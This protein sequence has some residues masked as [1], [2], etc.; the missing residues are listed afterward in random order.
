MLNRLNENYCEMKI[1]S[2]VPVTEVE[3]VLAKHN[4][5]VRF[6]NYD[7]PKCCPL[8][9]FKCFKIRLEPG[10]IDRLYLVGNFAK[11]TAGT[12]KII[13]VDQAAVLKQEAEGRSARLNTLMNGDDHFKKGVNLLEDEGFEPVLV[14][15]ALEKGSLLFIDGSH[16]AI[17]HFIRLG[18]LLDIEVY[19]CI[20]A[21]IV[22]YSLYKHVANYV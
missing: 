21:N 3:S 16:R 1:I 2:E 6:D 4:S 20:H 22:N 14:G 10:D 9:D 13:N 19:V 5:N 18:N 11:V 15:K 17:G 8:D 7:M 12:C